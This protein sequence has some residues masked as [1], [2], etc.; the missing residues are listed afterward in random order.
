MFQYALGRV[1]AEQ[2]GVP[3][4]I[5]A[6]WFNAAGWAEVSYFLKL[7]LRAKVVRRFSIGT[8]VLRKLTRKHYWEYR[9]VPVLREN[10][11]DQSF[12]SRFLAAPADCMLFGY[13][14]TPRYF[15]ARAAGFREELRGLLESGAGIGGEWRAKLGK[16]GT[17]AVHVR[18]TDYLTHP[19]FLVC[20]L[21]YYRAAMTRMREWVANAQ[22][23]IFSDD[24]AWCREMFRED[25]VVVVGSLAVNPLHDMYLMSLAS[26]HIIANSSYSWWGAWLA[27]QSGQRVI[28]PERWYVDEIVAP[29]EEKRMDHWSVL[30]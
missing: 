27:E 5:D 2:Y 8:R 24:P 9:G 17:V 25:D 14:Q 12:D 7:P 22:F 6:S 20:D 23:Y 26:H 28:M 11:L 13:F 10:P 29:I 4:V 3:L 19:V 1:L 30:Q 16:S 18:R 21:S 15:A